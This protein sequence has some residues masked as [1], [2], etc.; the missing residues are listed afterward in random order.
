MLSPTS[1]SLRA[2]ACGLASLSVAGCD[3]PSTHIVFDNRYS[4]EAAVPL[5][6]YDA[7]WVASSL[8]APL[9]PGASSGPL[10]T[11]PASANTVYAVLAPGW[12]P[13][14]G[15]LPASLVASQSRSGFAVE[16]DGTT[17]VPI[18]DTTFAGN[19]AAGSPLTQE[20]A[21]FLTQRVFANHF[22]G[23]AYDAATCTTSSVP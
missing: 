6:V 18:D 3:T 4:Q 17:H 23:L 2:L 15:S 19:C 11:V 16:L 13:A 21:D 7:L 10:G 8:P 12:D 9:L 22:A 20:Q 14:S 5:V 1:P